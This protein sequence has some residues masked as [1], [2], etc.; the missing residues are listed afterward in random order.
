MK[1]KAYYDYLTELEKDPDSRPRSRGAAAIKAR[2]RQAAEAATLVES[3]DGS[4]AGFNPSYAGSRHEREWIL[5]HLGPFYDD[6]ILADVLRQVKGGKEATVYC[7]RAHAAVGG[8]LLAAK[9]YRPRMFRNL[10]NDAVYRQGRAVLDSEGKQI[11]DGRQH[12]GNN[13]R[14]VQQTSWVATEFET[15]RRLH[16]AGVAVPRPIA[17]GENVIVMEYLGAAERAA[18]TLNTVTLDPAE[19]ETLCAALLGDV[20]R[21]L[22][23]DCIHGDLSAHNVLY[24]QGEVRII[25]FP[26]AVSPVENPQAHALLQRDVTRLCQY[27]HRFGIITDPDVIVADLWRGYEPL[28]A[29]PFDDM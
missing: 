8:G 1:M 22:A 21:M 25:D 11:R 19:A 23:Q 17:H 27:F 26:Q 29:Y 2:R 14:A 13:L 12:R 28:E 20:E 24:W 6:N 16:E 3:T 15:L 4:V 18:P 10:R 9:V 5:T 7:C